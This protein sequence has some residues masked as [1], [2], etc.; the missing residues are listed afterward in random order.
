VRPTQSQ[1]EANPVPGRLFAPDGRYEHMPVRFVRIAGEDLST[2]EHAAEVLVT[3][4]G[5]TAEAIE[6]HAQARGV[7]PR[8]ARRLAF[9]PDQR[10]GPGLGRGRA[11]ALV[12]ARGSALEPHAGRDVALSA[13]QEQAYQRIAGRINRLWSY[14]NPLDHFLF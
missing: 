3:V 8:R 9:S 13:E 2:L 7:N 1:N 12:G 6:E 10:G 4:A 11:A 5:E 14:G